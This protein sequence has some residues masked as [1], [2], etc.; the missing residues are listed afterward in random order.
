MTKKEQA[1]KTVSSKEE[2]GTQEEKVQPIASD[3]DKGTKSEDVEVK[4]SQNGDEN[5]STEVVIDEPSPDGNGESTSK[6]PETKRNIPAEVGKVS[7][8]EKQV[9]ELSQFQKDM[10]MINNIYQSN[11]AAYETF[12]QAYLTQTGSDLGNYQTRFGDTGLAGQP[13]PQTVPPQTIQTIREMV[14]RDRENEDGFKEFVKVVP[15]MN[16]DN[17]KAPEDYKKAESTWNQIGPIADRIRENIPGTTAAQA[18]I[19]A[20]NLLPDNE[21]R[22]IRNAEDKG[23]IVGRAEAYASGTGSE[24]SLVAGQSSAKMGSGKTVHLNSDQMKVYRNFIENGRADLARK[25]AKNVANLE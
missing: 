1:S 10:E 17:L 15:E 18:L 3:Q 6:E 20:Y 4:P 8:L 19:K 14:K 21:D 23:R 5:G 25:F 9:N 7:S 22:Q 24:S 16:P 12:R 11:P 13:Q 2:K